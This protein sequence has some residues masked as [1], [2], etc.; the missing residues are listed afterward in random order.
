M[1]QFEVRAVQLV[2]LV[3]ALGQPEGLVQVPLM[4]RGF[5]ALQAGQDFLEHGLV[6]ELIHERYIGEKF[7]LP[8]DIHRKVGDSLQVAGNRV[9]RP[10][11]LHVPLLQARRLD[12]NPVGPVHD[13]A[14][15]GIDVV[16]PG[17]DF[18]G[19]GGAGSG[20]KLQGLFDLGQDFLDHELKVLAKGR[21]HG[22]SKLA[23]GRGRIFS[24]AGAGPSVQRSLMVTLASSNF[25]RASTSR[26]SRPVGFRSRHLPSESKARVPGLDPFLQGRQIFYDRLGIL[27]GFMLEAFIACGHGPSFLLS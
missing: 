16:V 17:V 20:E 24:S 2:Q 21:K 7:R 19:Q 25:R 8:Q 18:L 6:I 13:E 15:Q 10:Q 11:H 27:Q 4:E 9:E 1:T 5:D 3:F 23:L 22:Y 14:L 26:R 12:Q